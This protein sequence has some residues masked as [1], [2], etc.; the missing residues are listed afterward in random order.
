MIEYFSDEVYR[1]RNGS[2][3]YN[4]FLLIS[5]VNVLWNSSGSLIA[6]TNNWNGLQVINGTLVYP[7][8][9]F[10]SVGSAQT[11]PNFGIPNRNYSTSNTLLTGFGTSSTSSP[12]N[13]RTYT[14][15][16]NQAVANRAT[17]RISIDF[18]GTTFVNSNSPLIG[19][20]P[21]W[22]EVKV[23]TQTGWLD[24]TKPYISPRTSNG[25]GCYTR[26]NLL[27]NT[28]NITFTLGVTSNFFLFRVT[29]NPDWTGH[30]R[31]ITV[32]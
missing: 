4:S 21:V 11:N 16:F 26:Y 25:D 32:S 18:V 30:I 14:R 8:F 23:A 28:L 27:G 22:I 15:Y 5:D 9:D 24:L 13:Y 31:R 1:K 29:A 19:N 2:N 7:K 6:D 17:W 20:T 12:T 3:K 10:N